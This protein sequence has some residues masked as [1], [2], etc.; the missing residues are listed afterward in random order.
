MLPKNVTVAGDTYTFYSRHAAS[1]EEWA[2]GYWTLG[3]RVEEHYIMEFALTEAD[4][5]AQMLIYLVQNKPVT[6]S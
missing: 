5:R 3:E 1:R 2:V 6:L 4:A